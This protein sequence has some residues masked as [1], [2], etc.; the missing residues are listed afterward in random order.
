MKTIKTIVNTLLVVFLLLCMVVIIA[1]SIGYDFKIIYT[2][3]K[4]GIP[5]WN[6]EYRLVMA[7]DPT[8]QYVI[9]AVIQIAN[10]GTEVTY[11]RTLF[12]TDDFWYHSRYVK[13]YGW[14]GETNDFYVESTDSGMIYYYYSDGTWISQQS[15]SPSETVGNTWDGSND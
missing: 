8:E 12:V 4:I 13:E 6:N 14:V 11:P 2:G 1:S 10:S 9:F 7:S 3:Q 15:V 5:S